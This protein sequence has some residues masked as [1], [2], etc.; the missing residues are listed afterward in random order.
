MGNFIRA[1]IFVLVALLILGVRLVIAFVFLRGALPLVFL[2]GRIVLIVAL[3]MRVV[4]LLV[5]VAWLRVIIILV[6]IP[7]VL[8]I[9]IVFLLR[10]FLL[11]LDTFRK[12]LRLR[13]SILF[14]QFGI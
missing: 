4:G 12:I 1:L 11:L 8:V 10:P 13:V 2:G 6:V 9:L 7:A 5:V 14:H 3:V